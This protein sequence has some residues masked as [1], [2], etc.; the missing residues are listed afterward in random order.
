MANTPTRIEIEAVLAEGSAERAIGQVSEKVAG[1]SR[2][3]LR[4]IQRENEALQHQIS[5][6][7]SIANKG[8]A[9]TGAVTRGRAQGRSIR[10]GARD[11]TI[12][13]AIRRALEER[14]GLE[15]Q[16]ANTRR[17]LSGQL[18]AGQAGVSGFFSSIAA[19]NEARG[20]AIRSGFGNLFGGP[21]GITTRIANRLGTDYD[22]LAAGARK[23]G[24]SL[25]E[26]I[27]IKSGATAAE[28][29][30][31]RQL[32]SLNREQEATR[33][34]TD[35]ATSG[36]GQMGRVLRSLLTA[37]VGFQV[38]RLIQNS[39]RDLIEFQAKLQNVKLGVAEILLV[40]NRFRDR[41]TG[42][43]LPIADQVKQSFQLAAR[44]TDSLVEKAIQLGLPLDTLIASFQTV[45]GIAASSG[46]KF[47]DTLDIITQIGV[48]SQRLN[49]PFNQLT[50]SIDNIFTGLRVQQTQLGVI[51]GLNQKIVQEQIQQGTLGQFLLERLQG[52]AETLPQNLQTF[53]G[54]RQS[55]RSLVLDLTRSL[56]GGAFQILQDSLLDLRNNLLALRDDRS[57][58]DALADSFTKLADSIA[59]SVKWLAQHAQLLKTIGYGALGYKLGG[60]PGAIAG[61]SYGAGVL[62]SNLLTAGVIGVGV[63]RGASALGTALSGLGASAGASTAVQG[64]TGVGTAVLRTLGIVAGGFTS[65]ATGLGIVTAA[66]YGLKR[67]LDGISEQDEEVRRLKLSAAAQRRSK[68]AYTIVG[69][70]QQELSPEGLAELNRQAFRRGP[71]G[72]SYAQA[73]LT[74]IRGRLA[75]LTDIA[76][77]VRDKESREYLQGRIAEF[78]EQLTNLEAADPS[79]NIAQRLQDQIKN[80]KKDQELANQRLAVLKATNDIA[81]QQIEANRKLAEFEKERLDLQEQALRASTDRQNAEARLGFITGAGAERSAAQG[82]IGIL[83]GRLGRVER[84]GGLAESVGRVDVADALRVEKVRLQQEIYALQQQVQRGNLAEAQDE[85]TAASRR[86]ADELKVQ[87]EILP[88][89]LRIEREILDLKIAQANA[90]AGAAAAEQKVAQDQLDLIRQRITAAQT[91]RAGVEKST[92][93]SLSPTDPINRAIA[94]YQGL[95]AQ[96]QL[97]ALEAQGRQVSASIE[98]RIL[99][100]QAGLQGQRDQIAYDQQGVKVA[101]ARGQEAQAQQKVNAQIQE[102]VTLNESFHDITL[103]QIEAVT[104]LEQVYADLFENMKQAIGE[105]KQLVA[106]LLYDPKNAKNALTNFTQNI[107]RRGTEAIAGSTIDNLI[108]VVGGSQS[109]GGALGQIVNSASFFTPRQPTVA[110]QNQ[111]GQLIQ[112]A[113]GIVNL[114]G[115]G[116]G[117]FT[118]SA[119]P[120]GGSALGTAGTVGSALYKGAGALGL[121]SYLPSG[122]TG[123]FGGGAAAATTAS[124]AAQAGFTAGYGGASSIVGGTSAFGATGAAGAGSAGVGAIG[125]AASSAGGVASVLAAIAITTQ[126]LLAASRAERFARNNPR[127]NASDIAGASVGAFATS[128]SGVPLGGL[129]KNGAAGQIGAGALGGAIAGALVGGAAA[130]GVGIIIGAI[131]AAILIAVAQQKTAGSLIARALVPALKDIGFTRDVRLNGIGY[132]RVPIS[133][134]TGIDK[135]LV[136]PLPESYA[137]ILS[138]ALNAGYSARST[139]YYNVGRGDVLAGLPKGAQAAILG[140][141]AGLGLEASDAL[142]A[143]RAFTKTTAGDF[144]KG[145]YKILARARSKDPRVALTQGQEQSALGALI[146]AFGELPASIDEATLAIAAFGKEGEVSLKRL[147]AAATDAKTVIQ[148]GLPKAL[149]DAVK[150]GNPIDAA[151]SLAQT[152]TDTFLNRLGQSLVSSGGLQKAL[153]EAVALSSQAADAFAAG[154]DSRGNALLRQ[155]GQAFVT[156]RNAYQTTVN[157]LYPSIVG[158]N[159]SVGVFGQGGVINPSGSGLPGF[160]TPSAVRVP[161]PVGQ[162]RLAVVHGDEVI[163]EGAHN[164]QLVA[165]MNNVADAQRELARVMLAQ[166][167]GDTT[168]EVHLGPEVIASATRKAD[169]R[170]SLGRG[171][172]LPVPSLGTN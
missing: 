130:A 7:E 119:I 57:T 56:T 53:E 58:I 134:R 101:E 63:G 44:G 62:S 29:R 139:Y 50:R 8:T 67:V 47:Q 103:D 2:T 157:R 133:L 91:E 111:I 142:D 165:A 95:E 85:Q 80:D 24:I 147:Q 61:A 125:S 87:N 140:T 55:L 88:E 113:G 33:K 77:R 73:R 136:N 11:A 35:K 28:A 25:Q 121:T 156:G 129:A 108:G 10:Q 49:I 36:F 65:F 106:D 110:Q 70:L 78:N 1:A 109:V 69:E 17:R 97:K 32:K 120:G 154:D 14:A 84:L 153:T 93:Q 81:V 152:F 34:A 171:I 51:L 105:I 102:G 126:G 163:R 90:T 135:G 107:R 72:R 54:I 9:L 118:T 52:V 151:T 137:S 138:P 5:L 68:D 143:V 144:T 75:V 66:L 158:F 18:R 96:A 20:R 117:G 23:A 161:G 12:E 168:V 141:A 115:G 166:S 48:V 38:F 43:I 94:D 19:Q 31:E 42:Q 131:V 71:I 122:I 159:A 100:K 16:E 27:R 30:N 132:G 64:V 60:V 104:K 124:S 169:R 6:L 39:I 15:I 116:L 92:G 167:G 79:A 22:G 86:L 40:G 98:A 170:D 76:P 89:R 127:Y 4:A 149:S 3:R 37:F 128:V 172:K 146:A 82:R 26:F 59:T 99:G 162:P 114:A 112:Q 145:G 164:D 74:D 45:A 148:N 21:A 41:V 160:A 155:A 13:E 123:L 83:Q 150:S 46:V